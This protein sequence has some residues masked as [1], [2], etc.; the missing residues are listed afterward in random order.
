MRRFCSLSFLLLL[1]LLGAFPDTPADF[2]FD[3]FP[4]YF[5]ALRDA[6]YAQEISADE[7][8]SSLYREAVSQAQQ[9]LSGAELYIMRSRCE[10]MLGHAY[11]DE[12]QKRE[13]ISC[14]SAGIDWAEKALEIKESDEGWQMLAENISRSCKVRPTS[15]AIAN[16]LKIEKYAKNALAKNSRNAAAQIMIASRW[17]YAPAPFGNVKKGIQM[18]MEIPSASN[19]QKDDLF[20]IYFA[21][22]YAYIQQKNKPEARSWL[23]KA[24]EIYPTN[25]YAR[26]L[27]KST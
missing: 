2:P 13:A 1:P 20:N 26:D 14:F 18:M 21:L 27:L 12:D 22:G 5:L 17:I 8:R 9:N 3:N 7:L 15:Y 10:Y 23:L 11:E 19:P 16:G 24:M 25:K 4:G 6:L